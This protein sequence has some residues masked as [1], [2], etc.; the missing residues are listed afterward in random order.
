[1]MMAVVLA[2]S[3]VVSYLMGG[4]NGAIVASRLFHRE[5]IREKGSGNPGFTNYKRV[6]GNGLVTW[7]VLIFDV[8]KTMFVVSITAWVM[9]A[10]FDQ[11]Q[12]GAQF[13]GLFCMLG[14]CFPV[15][16]GFKGGKAFIAGFAT[17]WFVDWRMTLIAMAIFFAVLFIGKYMSVAS[18]TAALSCPISLF[19]L[20]YSNVWV[21]VLAIAAAALVIIRHYPNFVK[22]VHGTESKFT[23][24][25]KH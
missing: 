22:L 4:L 8:V 13:A 15:W 1:M 2:V 10:Y 14:H 20:G 21:E 3:A 12:F 11:W 17:I 16:Y 19:Y 6:Y 7:L 23:L 18:C 9:W 25:S 24:S 5:D